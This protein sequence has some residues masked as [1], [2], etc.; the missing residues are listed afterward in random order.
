MVKNHTPE[1]DKA[2]KQRKRTNKK[3]PQPKISFF[4]QENGE[5]TSTE[6]EMEH[7]DLSFLPIAVDDSSSTE[8]E[9]LAKNPKKTKKRGRKVVIAYNDGMEPNCADDGEHRIVEQTPMTIEND[10]SPGLTSSPLEASP[11]SLVDL[12][13]SD[14]PTE[15]SDEHQSGPLTSI[16]ALSPPNS[17]P[18]HP[19][20]RPITTVDS[21][22]AVRRVDKRAVRS[23][24]RCT[25][26]PLDSQA[27]LM[28]LV[29]RDMHSQVH[30]LMGMA[31]VKP[32]SMDPAS[33]IDMLQIS[34]EVI[35]VSREWI[36]M[37]L[38]E[39]QSPWPV[40]SRD[41]TRYTE[42]PTCPQ[43]V[44]NAPLERDGSMCAVTL[45][46][47]FYQTRTE[48][49]RNTPLRLRAFIP[50]RELAES[51]AKKGEFPPDPCYLCA[52]CQIYDVNR[53]LDRIR[54][55][56]AETPVHPSLCVQNW[57]VLVDTADRS[58]FMM[59]DCVVNENGKHQGVFFP[60]PNLYINCL[61]IEGEV[62]SRVVR[63]DY[64]YPHD[65]RKNVRDF[66]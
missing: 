36:Q 60:F 41:V 38:C 51:Y 6:T 61:I 25:T 28:R 52:L 48:A 7:E 12:R 50:N 21:A 8:L 29:L 44:L 3:Q 13:S 47:S 56:H 11:V 4:L 54:M 19:G 5:S 15:R 37:N 39:V 42:D 9:V 32:C 1:M 27:Q 49:S 18:G 30:T 33:E 58:G 65:V 46:P 35:P 16:S 45:L 31:R 23:T 64:P 62:G 20:Q 59:N 26:V 40:C 43:S 34:K 55:T 10:F 57:R 53:H 17:E 14:Q 2:S 22:A 63:M 66:C 24:L